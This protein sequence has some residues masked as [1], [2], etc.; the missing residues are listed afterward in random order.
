MF[1]QTRYEQPEF[2]PVQ[3]SYCVRCERMRDQ[4]AGRLLRAE[5]EGLWPVTVELQ[6]AGHV[7]RR[8]VRTSPALGRTQPALQAS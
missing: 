7:W 5:M 1:D 2:M 3:P 6:P 8:R 4:V